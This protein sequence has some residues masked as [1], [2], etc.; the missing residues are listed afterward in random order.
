VFTLVIAKQARTTSDR[1]RK[2]E[3]Q[4]RNAEHVIR[5][6][7]KHLRETEGRLQDAQDRLRNAEDRLRE[8]KKLCLQTNGGHKNMAVARFRSEK[9]TSIAGAGIKFVVNVMQLWFLP[10][11]IF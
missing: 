9:D 8:T 6:K 11:P 10:E 3:H 7:E 5:E 4:I 2:A 1:L